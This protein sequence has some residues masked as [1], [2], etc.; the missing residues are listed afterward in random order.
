MSRSLVGP[1]RRV[2]VLAG[3]DGVGT[4][5]QNVAVALL[6]VQRF[7]IVWASLAIG[8]ATVGRLATPPLVRLL[9]SRPASRDRP[10]LVFN[11]AICTMT[12]S[13][14]AV[15]ALA[16]WGPLAAVFGFVA[17]WSAANQVSSTLAVAAV[18]ER[19]VHFG[20]FLIAGQ[21]VGAL[22]AV[23]SLESQLAPVLL[24]LLL[25]L[26]LLEIPLLRDVAFPVVHSET[27]RDVVPHAT[28][29]LFFA[30]L[31]YGPLT[32][33]AV[34]ATSVASAAWAGWSMAVY[35]AGGLLAPAVERRL[36]GRESWPGVLALGTAA[37]ATWLFAVS[38][39][40]MLA[41]R[42]AAGLLLFVAQGRLVRLALLGPNGSVST[43]R[44]SGVSTGLGAG[45]G[46]AGVVAGVLADV[47]VDFM[48][49]ALTAAGALAVAL[50]LGSSRSA[51]SP[52]HEP[53]SP[54]RRVPESPPGP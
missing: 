4:G 13:S 27:L 1:S 47:S 9:E 3:V 18:P 50:A 2:L 54:Q 48:A 43:V 53:S 26:Q 31:F 7:G 34:L 38:G 52:A 20:P 10:H 14:L 41:G 15:V 19:V 8:T 6:L 46:L 23:A 5:A 39:P 42:F 40:A 11:V 51:K 21:A 32:I 45:A 35:A 36:P 16:A 25:L 30:L 44:L 37:T 17:V 12:L 22:A 28:R 29:G 49:T 24:A 33:Y